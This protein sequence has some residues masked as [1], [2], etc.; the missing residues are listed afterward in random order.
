MRSADKAA[1]PF[2]VKH[3][4]VISWLYEL[5]TPARFHERCCRTRFLAAGRRMASGLI[6]T[7]L[8]FT[9]HAKQ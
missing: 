3:N 2:D 6:H 5:P 1:I 8:P 4:A 7:G 9:V